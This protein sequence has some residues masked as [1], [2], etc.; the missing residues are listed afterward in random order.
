MM[1][2]VSINNQEILDSLKE[3]EWFVNEKV[4]SKVMPHQRAFEVNREDYISEE[5]LN[6]IVS[7]GDNHNGFPEILKGYSFGHTVHYKQPEQKFV[8]DIADKYNETI[9]NFS[10][11]LMLK[12]NALFSVYP[13]GG[14]I[15]WHNNA[16]A[17]AYN[18]IFT[19]SENGNGY[20]QH[21]DP[22]TNEIVTIHDKPGWQCKA[23]YFGAYHEGADKIVYHCAST[24]CWRM[25]V[26]FVL[27]RSEISQGIQ[28][29]II[30]E[31]SFT[32]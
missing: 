7:M 18:F 11:S 13:P 8:K 25:T 31:L 22:K 1:K 15:S 20:W 21:L 29:L 17:S 24:D 14:F 12:R 3:F 23:G 6:K 2:D 4:C 28:D 32:E 27:D 26:A 30:E 5:Y 9:F 19:W 16:N 10:T